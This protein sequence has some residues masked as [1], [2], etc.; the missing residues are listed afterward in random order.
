MDGFLRFEAFSNENQ[1]AIGKALPNGSSQK[2]LGSWSDLVKRQNAS[3]LQAP[4]QVCRRGR[5][6]ENPERIILHEHCCPAPPSAK[7]NC[8]PCH[9]QSR[10]RTGQSTCDRRCRGFHG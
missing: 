10:G 8:R 7:A 5:L 2:R 6:L 4:K 9:W 1:G 3:L